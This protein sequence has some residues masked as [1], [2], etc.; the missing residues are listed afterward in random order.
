VFEELLCRIDRELTGAGIPYM[1]IGGQ[2]V[3]VYGEPRMTRDVDVTLGIP[4]TDA[5]RLLEILPRLKLRPL[6]TSP[7]DF[8]E[9]TFVLPTGT[10]SSPL[11]VDFI[12][13]LT[14][15]ERRALERACPVKL[16]RRAVRFISPEDLVIFKLLAGRSRD[17]EDVK[18]I[19][20]KIPRLDLG[21]IHTWI[22]SFDRELDGHTGDALRR[23]LHELA[24]ERRRSRPV[25]SARVPSPGPRRRTRRRRR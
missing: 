10:K 11:R 14:E 9:K 20:L 13:T 1:I 3:L 21:Y 22:A 24:V 7:V 5:R 15:Y 6:V 16:G 25:R 23:L 4:P 18:G 2:A 17:I 8:L 19:L 12:F